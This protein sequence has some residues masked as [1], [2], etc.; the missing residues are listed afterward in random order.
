MP[1]KLAVVIGLIL[2]LLTVI[3]VVAGCT[4]AVF[5]PAATAPAGDVQGGGTTA[6]AAGENA[7]VTIWLDPVRQ[8]YIEKYK[9]LH[10]EVA[11]LVKV[12]IANDEVVAEK[13]LFFNNANE[14]WPDIVWSWPSAVALFSDEAHHF[15]LDLKEAISQE[16]LDSFSPGALADCTFDGHLNCLP[17]DLAHEVLWYDAKLMEAYGYETPTTWEAYQ[18]LGEK[19]AQEHPGTIIGTCGDGQCVSDYFHPSRCPIADVRASDE[20]HISVDMSD[21]RCTRVARMLDKLIADG[22]V[23]TL[24][25]FDTA[26]YNLV[27]DDK[28]LMLPAPVWFGEY[29]FGGRPDSPYYQTA[30]GRL[31]VAMPLKWADQDKIYNGGSTGGVWV[32]SNHTQNL[33]LAMDILLFLTTS[34]A[35]QDTAVTY[36]AY[37]PAT[38]E[39]GKS[40]VEN[41]VYAFD[42]FPVLEAAA[43]TLTPEGLGTVRYFTL[44]PLVS[45]VLSQM[46]E[47]KTMLEALPGYGKELKGLAGAAGYR[48]VDE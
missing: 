27:K 14:G 10:P 44:D 8:E 16:A 20:V 7:P 12:E 39:W 22:A 40:L 26:F 28:L 11:D 32:V 38:M 25:P 34:H 17:S 24:S 13:I 1:R 33:D 18:A 41:E 23:A 45:G 43:A 37:L 5:T 30:D 19:V 21:P 9:E 2:L 29:M 48:V 47:G 42:P 31:G 3:V 35:V 15:P 4:S 36:P 6:G 46:R